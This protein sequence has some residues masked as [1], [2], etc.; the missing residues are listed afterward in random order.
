[1]LE[2]SVKNPGRDNISHDTTRA[3]WNARC[4][5]S[6]VS[7][8]RRAP[9]PQ[10][11]RRQPRARPAA[12]TRARMHG[13]G[14]TRAHVACWWHD[15]DRHSANRSGVRG[16]GRPGTLGSR[17]AQHAHIHMSANCMAPC[18]FAS[19]GNGRLFNFCPPSPRHRVPHVKPA[20]Q[21]Q[22][23]RWPRHAARRCASRWHAARQER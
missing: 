20:R 18:R 6:P 22:A 17:V 3:P 13:D 21:R 15:Q 5:T 11:Q 12:G 4:K 1:M 7:V 19:S 10:A 8:T 16:R 14:H 2:C 9:H 23:R